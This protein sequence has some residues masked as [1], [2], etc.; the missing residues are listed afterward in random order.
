LETCQ[1]VLSDPKLEFQLPSKGSLPGLILKH[2]VST[3]EKKLHREGPL[4]W[5]VGITHDPAFRFWNPVFGYAIDRHQK[6]QKMVILYISHEHCGPAF[7]EAALIHKF[8]GTLSKSYRNSW[9][10]LY[11][12]ELT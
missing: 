6:W 12:F 7:L 3:V 2:G 8:K 1:V 9:L 10:L 5:K 4:V 11:R